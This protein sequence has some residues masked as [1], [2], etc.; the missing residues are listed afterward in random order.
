[1]DFWT[2]LKRTYDSSSPGGGVLPSSRALGVEIDPTLVS[3]ARERSSN[4]TLT[5]SCGDAGSVPFL[6]AAL[7]AGLGRGR[8]VT[9]VSVFS[10]TMWLHMHLGDAAF[11]AWLGY[12]CSRAD[13]VLIEP[14][15]KRCY[16]AANKR[17]RKMGR[18]QVDLRG[19]KELEGVESR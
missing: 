16:T 7:D 17:L 12:V 4:P 3:R 15:P 6:S 9:L 19:L 2:S 13:H 8:R 1:M 11:Y 10:T 14:Q 5:F 18:P